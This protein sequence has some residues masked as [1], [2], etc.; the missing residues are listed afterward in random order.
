MY[1][2]KV[3]ISP[4]LV[5]VNTTGVLQLAGTEVLCTEENCEAG[6]LY[7]KSLR[8]LIGIDPSFH[9]ARKVNAMTTLN[10]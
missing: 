8:P 3:D 6:A 7:H 2:T 9:V 10:R 5:F 1:G 4:Y